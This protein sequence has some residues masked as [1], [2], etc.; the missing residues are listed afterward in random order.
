MHSDIWKGPEQLQ[1]DLPCSKLNTDRRAVLGANGFRNQYFL[2]S[3]YSLCGSIPDGGLSITPVNTQPRETWT[4]LQTPNRLSAS[5][6]LSYGRMLL[7]LHSRNVDWDTDSLHTFIALPT[8]VVSWQITLFSGFSTK[9][10]TLD[11]SIVSFRI[12]RIEVYE[13]VGLGFS[14]RIARRVGRLQSS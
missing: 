13:T 11:H 12:P 1:D 10:T 4:V 2:S 9:C 8:S 14:E 6:S 3:S 7:T 5:F